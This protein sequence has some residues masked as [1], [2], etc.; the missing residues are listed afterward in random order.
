[1]SLIMKWTKTN[2][3]VVG[4]CKLGLE[5]YWENDYHYCKLID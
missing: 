3:Q 4:P 5:N 2:F 1:M